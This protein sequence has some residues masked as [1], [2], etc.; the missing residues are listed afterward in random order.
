[1]KLYY[2]YE[3]LEDVFSD[4]KEV[5]D[6]QVTNWSNCTK[7]DK[8][9]NAVKDV[10]LILLVVLG[11]TERILFVMLAQLIRYSKVADVT[12]IHLS[13]QSEVYEN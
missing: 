2:E 7:C 3:K 6:K 12:L 10:Y 13:K 9:A 11:K 8:I 1:M 4:R 5:L